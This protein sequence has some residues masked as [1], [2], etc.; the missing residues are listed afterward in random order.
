[1]DAVTARPVGQVTSLIGAALGADIDFPNS[2]EQLAGFEIELVKGTK[3][4]RSKVWKDPLWS[5]SSDEPRFVSVDGHHAFDGMLVKRRRPRF[6][7]RAAQP[8]DAYSW[9]LRQDGD[10]IEE[11]TDVSKGIAG[12][13]L[14]FTF[15]PEERLRRSGQRGLP[16]RT[17]AFYPP[18][19]SHLPNMPRSE[20]S[21]IRYS[22]LTHAG[23]DGHDAYSVDF[24]WGVGGADKGHWVRSAAAGRVTKVDPDNGQVHIKH[25]RFDGKSS[26]ETVYAHM[27][28]VLVKRGERVAAQQRIG[29]IGAQYHGSEPISPH[30]HHQHLKDG[31]PIKMKLLIYGEDTPIGVSRPNP[32]RTIVWDSKVPGWIQPRGPAPARIAG[33][34]RS[35]SDLSQCEPPM[36]GPAP[37]RSTCREPRANGCRRRCGPGS[38]RCTR[39]VPYRRRCTRSRCPPPASS[40]RTTRP[41][42]PGC[43]CPWALPRTAARSERTRL[44]H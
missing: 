12:D 13:G 40:V 5:Y 2:G 3:G 33:R 43:P 39:P 14:S 16:K 41:A 31:Q 7:L 15:R 38:G 17:D 42:H 20:D 27:D 25:P 6:R 8:I 35:A 30:L 21:R 32:N 28:P 36:R 24:N 18:V 34:A 4:N 9:V 19:E 26:Y 29:K 11:A 10:V 44:D 37:P 22:A 23:H 1:M